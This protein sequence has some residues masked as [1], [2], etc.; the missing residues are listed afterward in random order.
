MFYIL[1]LKYEAPPLAFLIL[2]S[3]WRMRYLIQNE[4]PKYKIFAYHATCILAT[5][6]TKQQ[7]WKYFVGAL[8]PQF[9]IETWNL[10]NGATGVIHTMPQI[11]REKLELVLQVRNFELFFNDEWRKLCSWAFPR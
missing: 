2:W 10:D 1:H 5:L 4:W 3:V 6:H 9:I 8:Y 11:T 7:P